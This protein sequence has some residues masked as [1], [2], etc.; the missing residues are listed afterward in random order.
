MRHISRS[1]N[2]KGKE[3]IILPVDK[4]CD[5][6][7][8]GDECICKPFTMRKTDQHKAMLFYIACVALLIGASAFIVLAVLLPNPIL[9]FV[10]L[11]VSFVNFTLFFLM[12]SN[13]PSEYNVTCTEYKV[14]F[15]D[16]G[17]PRLK[18][19]Y[20]FLIDVLIA[21]I[22]LMF[23]VWDIGHTIDAIQNGISANNEVLFMYFWYVDGWTLRAQ[24]FWDVWLAF[25]GLFLFIIEMVVWFGIRKGNLCS[26]QVDDI[27][28]FGLNELQRRMKKLGEE[29]WDNEPKWKENMDNLR[30][31]EQY[32]NNLG[33]QLD[34]GL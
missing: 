9:C 32:L 14:F 7:C 11:F 27:P 1:K 22:P 28:I 17:I 24:G 5:F 6:E 8:I 4:H 21:A 10:L 26:T 30:E 33:N 34:G 16:I 2:D 31:L 18:R 23:F 13:L 15:R 12:A 20:V 19:K 25:V 3:E 29:G